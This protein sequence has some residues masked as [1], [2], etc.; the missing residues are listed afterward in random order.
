M[1][2]R[3]YRIRAGIPHTIALLSD[4]HNADAHGAVTILRHR[5]PDLIAVTGDLFNGYEAREGDDLLEAQTREILGD[6]TGVNGV[7]LVR[8]NGEE[9]DVAILGSKDNWYDHKVTVSNPVPKAD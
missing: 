5:K 7:R 1:K 2:E 9:F 8:K 3:V 6:A 4:L